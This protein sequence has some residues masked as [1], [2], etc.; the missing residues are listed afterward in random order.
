MRVVICAIL[1]FISIYIDHSNDHLSS[2]R[3]ALS[4]LIYPVQLA[5]NT[6][7]T[8]V[9]GGIN[10]IKSRSGLIDENKKLRTE[11]VR[12]SQ[13]ALRFRAL[14]RENQRLRELLDSATI[15]EEHVVVADVLAVTNTPSKRQLVLDPKRG[16]KFFLGQPIVDAYGVIGQVSEVGP[17]SAT[18]ILITDPSHSLPVSLNRN[19][20]RAV[21]VGTDERD[22]LKLSYIPTHADIEIGDLVITSGLGSRFPSGYPVG[23]IK[24]V[25]NIPGELFLEVEVEPSGRIGR[26]RQVL[27]IGRAPEVL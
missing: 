11:N 19:G 13:R 17:F 9:A 21:A 8:L 4:V 5:V 24:N 16:S 26:T 10:N 18:A 20:L 3:S 6:P 7:I 22:I 27:L 12:L 2:I 14:E 1:S 25:R 15:F 23:I